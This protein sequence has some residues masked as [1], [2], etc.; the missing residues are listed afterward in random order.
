MRAMLPA[1][2][3]WIDCPDGSFLHWNFACIA[4]VHP[5]ESGWHS[6]VRWR[7]REL[8]CKC[9]GREQGKRWIERWLASR[10]MPRRR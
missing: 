10:G 2:C 1:Q 3:R 8:T 5:N 9:A 6:T 4:Y 7:G